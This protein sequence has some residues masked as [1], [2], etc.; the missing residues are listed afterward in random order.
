MHRRQIGAG[1]RTIFYLM[2]KSDGDLATP[3][4]CGTGARACAWQH[5]I[6]CPG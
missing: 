3:S 6:S 5:F 1:I 2:R 4:G